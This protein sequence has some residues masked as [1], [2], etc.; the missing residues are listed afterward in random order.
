MKE[1]TAEQKSDAS[2][3]RSAAKNS[4][5]T[6]EKVQFRQHQSTSPSHPTPGLSN[7]KKN[8][9]RSTSDMSCMAT[10]PIYFG[11]H[12]LMSQSPSQIS[13]KTPSKK[14]FKLSQITE[15]KRKLES[16]QRKTERKARAYMNLK[17][18]DLIKK[19]IKQK[20]LK[21]MH[22]TRLVQQI[23]ISSAQSK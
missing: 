22:E 2:L 17:R 14:L 3:A 11:Q 19:H 10:T 12:K 18:Q 15:I 7:G 21:E 5:A 8:G 16:S 9:G 23:L 20:V 13:Q 1:S 6:V 4:H